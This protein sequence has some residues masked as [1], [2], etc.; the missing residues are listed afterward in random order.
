MQ[1]QDDVASGDSDTTLMLG[2]ACEESDVA[3]DVVVAGAEGVGVGIAP[4]PSQ[5]PPPESALVVAE[6]EVAFS[7]DGS[8]DG[9]GF[10]DA[11]P[12]PPAPARPPSST[13]PR[14]TRELSL[15]SYFNST[16]MLS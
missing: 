9:S 6:A 13:R 7:Q 10:D 14:E 12:L 3:A 2:D 11:P 15:R 8:V 4:S 16:T 1:D 5:S